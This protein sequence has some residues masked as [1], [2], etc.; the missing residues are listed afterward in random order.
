MHWTCLEK[1][2]KLK[3]ALLAALL[4]WG[5]GVPL[6]GQ[7]YHAAQATNDFGSVPT[8]PGSLV[9]D[10]K[11]TVSFPKMGSISSQ[12]IDM[13]ADSYEYIG[14]NLIARGHA[15][16]RLKDM[17]I[18]ADSVVI[19]LLTKDMEA[20]GNVI[21]SARVSK[22]IRVSASEYE[23]F[24]QDPAVKIIA[25]GIETLPDG[26]QSIKATLISNS[27]YMKAERA[28]GSLE[29]GSFQFRNFFIKAGFMYF[30]GDLA[31]RYPNGTLKLFG[32][33][34]T[35]CEYKMDSNAHYEVES[36]EMTLKPREAN[37]SIYNYNPDHG[38]HS[39][40]ALNNLIR[41]WDFPV[42]WIPAFYKPADSNT[43]GIRFQYG[44]SSRWGNYVRTSKE[45]ELL[46]EPAIVRAAVMIDY[47]QQRGLGLG[48]TADILTKTSKTEFFGYMINDRNPYDYWNSNRND[49]PDGYTEQEWIKKYSRFEIPTNRYELRLSNITHITPRLDF[50]G[51][52]DKISDYNFLQDYFQ[53]RYDNDIQPPTFAAFE[54]QGERFSAT[55]QTVVKVNSFDTMLNRL[56]ELRFDFQRQELF[57]NI[58]YQGQTSAGYYKMSWRDYTFS[59]DENP[60]INFNQILIDEN[61]EDLIP[62]IKA[63]GNNTQAA[64]Q[65]L[66]N[67]DPQAFDPY[68]QDPKDY[69]AFR[70]D[71]LHAFYYP[72]KVF[73]FINLIPRAVGRFTAYSQSSK[74]QMNVEDLYSIY[75]DDQLDNWPPS[76]LKVDNYDSDGGAQFRFAGELGLEGNTKIYRAWQTPKSA[77]LQID[78][79]RHIAVPYF[80]LVFAP[81]PSV[82]YENLYYFDEVDQ[83][84]QEAFIRL[85]LQ[86]R[87]QTRRNN[88]LYEWISLENYW[89]YHFDNT[90]G[91]NHIGD[92]G[93]LFKFSPT[94]NL[95]FS[96]EL[97]LDVGQNGSHDATV[98]RGDT[99]AGRPGISGD[100]INRL[101]M[102][103]SYKITKDWIL[104]GSYY[105][106]DAYA[107][108][109]AYSMGSTLAQ[110][111]STSYFK[112]Y[113]NR[114]QYLGLALNF[115][116]IIDDRLKGK[117]FMAYDVDANLFNK[118]GLSVYRDFHC[119]YVMF[120]IGAYG[121]RNANYETTW[122]YYMDL[123]V[124]ITA[125]PGMAYTAS[126][127]VTYADDN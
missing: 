5:C 106:S 53:G 120:G 69:S 39:V 48:G 55:L 30:T 93:T 25:N 94:E 116:S 15:V 34:M 4:F 54:Y 17:Q 44:N 21:F 7:F 127:S 68:F 122:P 108:R 77:L 12:D 110:V 111:N 121:E 100:L 1:T 9:G 62:V 98:I 61:R 11:N 23:A 3:L 83:L 19:N 115:P 74:N 18:T 16:I 10:L 20:A 38:E 43:F 113:F 29:T 85:G 28:S 64:A 37:R 86:N 80:N 125:M 118:L 40:L 8:N 27:A 50:R 97:L 47:Y 96:T 73:D 33:R 112:T 32:A 109:T 14:S 79:L 65:Y 105:Y 107:Q 126:R 45:F 63:F 52:I 114:H 124:G 70:F 57:K 2:R 81:P 89:D 24:L 84:D 36:K 71:T 75:A 95:L 46:S 60:N 22:E 66:M 99:D 82:S 59:R 42:L 119:W 117:I 51:Q 90:D 103:L 49:A 72:F 76:T 6:Y 67:V 104:T 26:N 123:T 58:Y 31:D 35:T 88:Q 91:F 101:N 92:L 102:A 41:I 78:G 56:P 13:S 87:L